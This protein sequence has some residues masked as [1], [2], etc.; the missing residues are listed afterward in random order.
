MKKQADASGYE[1]PP[2]TQFGLSKNGIVI[3]SEKADLRR[4]YLLNIARV[5][6]GKLIYDGGRAGTYGDA[7][8]VPV[9]A[10]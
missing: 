9:I 7:N 3:L 8:G 6:L 10:D 4:S 1:R 2:K 5:G